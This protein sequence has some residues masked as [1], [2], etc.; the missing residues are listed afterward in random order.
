MRQLALE[1]STN[2]NTHCITTN[3]ETVG[4]TFPV[5]AEMLASVTRLD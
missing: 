2:L 1:Y 4:T 5:P 3:S